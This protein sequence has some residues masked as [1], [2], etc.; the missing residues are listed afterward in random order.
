MMTYRRRS[1][2]GVDQREQ[3]WKILRSGPKER[4]RDA[5][6]RVGDDG[7]QTNDPTRVDSLGVCLKSQEQKNIKKHKTK[8]QRGNCRASDT[9]TRSYRRLSQC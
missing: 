4:C 6:S 1:R 8:T 2:R 5:A 7:E 3:L 9:R